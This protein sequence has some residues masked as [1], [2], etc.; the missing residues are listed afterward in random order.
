M[1]RHEYEKWQL[2]C[3]EWIGEGCIDYTED[4]E[5]CR[6]CADIKYCQQGN[7]IISGE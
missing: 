1:T 4:G 6:Q 7:D 5:Q 3:E 2:E